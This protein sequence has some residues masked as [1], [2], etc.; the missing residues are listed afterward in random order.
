MA[1]IIKAKEAATKYAAELQPLLS[2]NKAS[3][4]AESIELYV[5]PDQQLLTKDQK[6]LKSNVTIP[7]CLVIPAI[8]FTASFSK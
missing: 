3:F 5:I 1:S 6:D 7:T 2:M 4:L 8:N